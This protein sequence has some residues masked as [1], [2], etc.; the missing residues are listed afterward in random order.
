MTF[1][2]NDTKEIM[3]L[4][5]KDIYRSTP[6]ETLLNIYLAQTSALNIDE[7]TSMDLLMVKLADGIKYH[8]VKKG[9]SK[10]ER[11][12]VVE[13]PIDGRDK[14]YM[15][16]YRYFDSAKI[17]VSASISIS[18]ADHIAL[19]NAFADAVRGVLLNVRK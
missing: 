16:I 18:D 1:N 11:L 15:T 3:G 10:D 17:Q 12:Y 19:L 5:L 4:K 7:P 6:F 2:I 14:R 8:P 13:C 9:G